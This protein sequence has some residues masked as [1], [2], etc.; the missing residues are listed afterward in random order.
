MQS[1]NAITG[2]FTRYEVFMVEENW[3]I[4][5]GLSFSGMMIVV[6]VEPTFNLW[7][8]EGE[9]EVK[10]TVISSSSSGVLSGIM[11]MINNVSELPKNII[12]SQV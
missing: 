3:K 5:P 11:V 10:I 12:F 7:V 4:P 9:T 6:W 2:T 8:S 1:I